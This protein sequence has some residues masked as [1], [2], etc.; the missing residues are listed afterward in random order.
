MVPQV[1]FT[2]VTMMVILSLRK[3]D[4]FLNNT[5][6]V[7]SFNDC[8]DEADQII[9]PDSARL[10]EDYEDSIQKA[11]VVCIIT[12]VLAILPGLKIMISSV[13][14]INLDCPSPD[15]LQKNFITDLHEFI[16]IYKKNN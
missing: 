10:V 5:L 13:F 15:T 3:W 11:L 14:G 16:Q 9:M 7:D 1:F 6:Y 2:F 8:L 12:F 4:R